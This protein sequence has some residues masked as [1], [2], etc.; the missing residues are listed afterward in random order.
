[1]NGVLWAA[2]EGDQQYRDSGSCSDPR[3]SLLWTKM[4]KKVLAFIIT[5][6][7]GVETRSSLRYESVL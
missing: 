1:M 7:L 2:Y 5:F 4:R 6:L 3:G